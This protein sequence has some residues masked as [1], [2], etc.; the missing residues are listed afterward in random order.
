A[1]A[2]HVPAAVPAPVLLQARRAPPAHRLARPPGNQGAGPSV[3]HGAN[4]LPPP[5]H[6]P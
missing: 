1:R 3:G 2:H 5:P 4:L 6:A